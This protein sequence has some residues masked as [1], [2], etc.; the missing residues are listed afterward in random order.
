VHS[1]VSCDRCNSWQEMS[2]RPPHVR[3]PERLRGLSGV[4]EILKR[5]SMGSVSPGAQALTAGE[6]S[7][8]ETHRY[9]EATADMRHPQGT[10][11]S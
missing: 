3:Y 9:G 8:A 11:L 7:F 1:A 2:D 10:P 5:T 4:T 6:I